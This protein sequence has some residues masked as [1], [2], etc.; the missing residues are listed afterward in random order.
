MNDREWINEVHRLDA[1]VPEEILTLEEAYTLRMGDF[2]RM[3][4]ID[5]RQM[6][7]IDPHLKALM[8]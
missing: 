5:F 1:A 6:S 4:E 8:N 3:P 2:L 7:A